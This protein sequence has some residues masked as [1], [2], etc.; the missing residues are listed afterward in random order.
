M[1]AR[2]ALAFYA[3][4]IGALLP[5]VL[6]GCARMPSPR[7]AEIRTSIVSVAVPAPCP[8]AVERDRLRALR[9]PLLAKTPMPPTPIER[10]A[11]IV[12]QLGLYEAAGGWADQVD[13]AL[14]RCQQD[15]VR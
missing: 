11:R 4:L 12:A 13:A 2:I 5:L 15:G 7:P 9:P 1:K 3:L 14:D 8:V 6:P 10:V